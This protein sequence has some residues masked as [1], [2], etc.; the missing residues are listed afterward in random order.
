MAQAKMFTPV[1]AVMAISRTESQLEQVSPLD[2]LCLTSSRNR[3]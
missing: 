3:S 1:L 2:I